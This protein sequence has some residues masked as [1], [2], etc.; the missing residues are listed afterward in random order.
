MPTLHQDIVQNPETYFSTVKGHLFKCWNDRSDAFSKI[1]DEAL[2]KI[3]E[4]TMEVDKVRKDIK[5]HMNTQVNVAPLW[6]LFHSLLFV[7]GYVFEM[8][9]V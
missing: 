8:C 9:T 2:K 7:S 1:A 3:I 4:R 6:L 5:E